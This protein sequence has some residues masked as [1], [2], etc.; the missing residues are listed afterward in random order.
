[1]RLPASNEEFNGDA[2]QIGLRGEGPKVASRMRQIA[3]V[4]NRLR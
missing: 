4:P 1:M 3:N 2:G